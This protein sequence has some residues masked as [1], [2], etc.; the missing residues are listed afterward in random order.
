MT[1]SHPCKARAR[2]AG[3]GRAGGTTGGRVRASSCNGFAGVSGVAPPL[4]LQS[5]PSPFPF[6]CFSYPLPIYFPFL[7][8]VLPLPYFLPISSPAH[9]FHFHLSRFLRTYPHLIPVLS[10]LSL[11]SSL[12]LPFLSILCPSLSLLTLRIPFP[13]SPIP[14]P[15]LSL[16]YPSSIHP[17]PCLA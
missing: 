10:F 15:S 16:F 13:F 11:L 12:S 14:C 6:L 1:A 2:R 9:Y 4:E 7:F 3:G 8:P 5:Y 17:R